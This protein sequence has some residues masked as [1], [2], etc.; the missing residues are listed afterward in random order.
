MRTNPKRDDE[1]NRDYLDRLVDED[2][3][4]LRQEAYKLLSVLE[5][6]RDN[7]H[8]AIVIGANSVGTET[9]DN[10][11]AKVGMEYSEDG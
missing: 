2:P 10:M 5:D 11:L 3:T 1:D 6:I 9:L 4:M 8:M 7:V